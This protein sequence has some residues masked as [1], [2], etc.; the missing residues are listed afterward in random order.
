MHCVANAMESFKQVGVTALD[1]A[2]SAMGIHKMLE[3]VQQNIQ[4]LP[5]ANYSWK[6]D[7]CGRAGKSQTKFSTIYLSNSGFQ[8]NKNFLKL[9]KQNCF[10]VTL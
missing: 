7:C 10:F 3:A 8:K 1:K 5:A 6:L 9:P 2:F 4:F